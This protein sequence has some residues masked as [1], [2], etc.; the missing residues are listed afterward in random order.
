V[1]AH[2]QAFRGQL[3]LLMD[4]LVVERGLSERTLEAYTRDL[5]DYAHFLHGQGCDSFADATRQHV[6]DYLAILTGRLALK[7]SSV[8]R[9]LGSIRRMHRF[10]VQE[11]L[12]DS[13][14]TANIAS[15]Q[16]ARRLPKV[17][18]VE[19]CLALLAAPNR[20]TPEGLRDSAMLTLMY[21]TGLRVSE[22]VSLRMHNVDFERGTVRVRGKGDK[23]RIVPVAAPALSLL[24][25]YV[26]QA[27]GEL[28]REPGEEG[29]FLTRL[30]RPMTRVRFFQL[31]KGYLPAAGAP[32]DTSPHTLRH[33]FATHLMEGGADLRVIQELL[34]HA[35]LATTE[36]YTHVSAERLQEVYEQKHPRA[37][38]PASREAS[39][40]R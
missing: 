1:D 6:I 35:S 12:C 37:R 5:T 29:L 2:L 38:R 11:R 10:L 18:T 13:D 33:S 16:P 14:P 4:H 34:G 36:I 21:A 15:P 28:T 19:Q 25:R 8:T 23:D 24:T 22:L 27:R 7:R 30:G 20:D 32:R 40:D 17:L 31:L 39:R 26:E 3:D 9:K